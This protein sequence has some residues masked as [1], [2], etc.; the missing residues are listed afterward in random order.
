MGLSSCLQGIREALIHNGPSEVTRSERQAPAAASGAPAVHDG[1]GYLRE[2]TPLN[3]EGQDHTP[4]RTH[5]GFLTIDRLKSQE[6]SG[7][8]SEEA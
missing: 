4:F 6:K 2:L 7:A 5:P 3:R 1:V 8:V